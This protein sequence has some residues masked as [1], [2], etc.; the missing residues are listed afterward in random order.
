MAEQRRH[1]TRLKVQ[2]RWQQDRHRKARGGE[3]IADVLR[4]FPIFQDTA[5]IERRTER[6]GPRYRSARR[7]R[8]KQDHPRHQFADRHQ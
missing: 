2:R 1:N 8:S 4:D 5:R 3:R 6:A 7:A